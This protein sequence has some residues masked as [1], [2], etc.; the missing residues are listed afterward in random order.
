MYIKKLKN[1]GED[2]DVNNEIKHLREEITRLKIRLRELDGTTETTSMVCGHDVVLDHLRKLVEQHELSGLCQLAGTDSNHGWY[3]TSIEPNKIKFFLEDS[4]TLREFL[5]LFCKK[6]VWEIM[7]Q[8]FYNELNSDNSD[9]VDLLVEKDLI[10]DNKLTSKGFTCYAVLGHL[11]F[12][13]TKKLDADTT[14]EIFKIAYD[15]TGINYGEYLPYTTNEFMELISK[16][17]KYTE[18]LEKGIAQK[19]INEY[20]RQNNV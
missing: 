2:M 18:L 4:E 1:W 10:K 3:T 6:G 11:A 16:H 19:E 12:N 17:P 5:S 8:A 15:M 7:E 13:M 9:L 14:I 20:L